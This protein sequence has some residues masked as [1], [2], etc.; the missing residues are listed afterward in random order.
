MPHPSQFLAISLLQPL[1]DERC[2]N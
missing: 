2:P 1:C